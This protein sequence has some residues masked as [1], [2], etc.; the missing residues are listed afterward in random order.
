M[1]KLQKKEFGSLLRIKQSRR[2]Q[3]HDLKFPSDSHYTPNGKLSVDKI[4]IYDK[5]GWFKSDS[6]EKYLDEIS[7]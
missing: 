3:C 6:R 1:I 7:K 5:C 2:T 4:K